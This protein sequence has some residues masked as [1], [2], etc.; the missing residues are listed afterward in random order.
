MSRAKSRLQVLLHSAKHF[1]FLRRP[2]EVIDLYLF[3]IFEFLRQRSVGRA[4]Y[5]IIDAPD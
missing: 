1:Y 2:F 5:P 3:V 4:R